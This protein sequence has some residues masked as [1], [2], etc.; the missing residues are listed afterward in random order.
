[1]YCMIFPDLMSIIYLQT[2][3]ISNLLRFEEF[4]WQDF[5]AKKYVIFGIIHLVSKNV[6][7]LLQ[8]K[9]SDYRSHTIVFGTAYGMLNI[10]K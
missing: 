10:H 3:K 9:N 6:Q 2:Y 4:F 7:K 1:M 5:R 8:E